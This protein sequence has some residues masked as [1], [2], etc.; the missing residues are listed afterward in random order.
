MSACG[1]DE[2][3]YQFGTSM[4]CLIWYIS[5]SFPFLYDLVLSESKIC[6]EFS[7]F[8]GWLIC[9]VCMMGLVA[10][11]NHL[12]EVQFQP[13][14]LVQRAV[15]VPNMSWTELRPGVEQHRLGT[16]ARGLARHAQY[17]SPVGSSRKLARSLG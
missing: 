3:A 13:L 1:T 6:Q 5:F 2:I 4:V 16:T 7:Q 9:W 11:P 17:S 15:F 8:F 10:C 12:R 14:V